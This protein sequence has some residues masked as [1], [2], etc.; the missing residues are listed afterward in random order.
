MFS[1]HAIVLMKVNSVCDHCAVN[2]ELLYSWETPHQQKN[3][4]KSL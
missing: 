1:T 4:P 2:A 3:L